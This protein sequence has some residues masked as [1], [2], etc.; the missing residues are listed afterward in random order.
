LANTIYNG[1]GVGDFVGVMEFCFVHRFMK[2]IDLLFL[3]VKCLY[4]QVD[5]SQEE[6]FSG[7]QRRGRIYLQK[8][9]QT[10]PNLSILVQA[11]DDDES[12]EEL[13]GSLVLIQ[14]LETAAVLD[15]KWSCQ[16][17]T[18]EDGREVPILVSGKACLIE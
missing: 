5:K 14:T 7:S 9:V 4:H 17:H 1:G 11:P 15:L 3:P 13:D 16:T 6:E 10:C 12:S 8:F 18:L 2:R